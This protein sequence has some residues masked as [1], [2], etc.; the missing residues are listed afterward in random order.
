MKSKAFQ[1]RFFQG[2]TH[3]EIF[4]QLDS[5]QCIFS[6]KLS[7]FT[8]SCVATQFLSVP[9][10]NEP[11]LQTFPKDHPEQEASGGAILRPCFRIPIMLTVLVPCHSRRW[12]PGTPQDSNRSASPERETLKI[13]LTSK[14]W[15]PPE[16]KTNFVSVLTVRLS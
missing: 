8:S 16:L 15:Q 7:E 3:F 1:R 14:L 10:L 12:L 13:P 11:H 6:C 2:A 4:R 5:P 9:F